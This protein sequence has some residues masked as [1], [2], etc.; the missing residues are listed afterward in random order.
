[1]K[2][3]LELGFLR[4]EQTNRLPRVNRYCLTTRAYFEKKMQYNIERFDR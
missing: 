1:M 4:N 2:H 3:K